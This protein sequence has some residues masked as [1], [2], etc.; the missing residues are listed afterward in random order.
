MPKDCGRSTVRS[1][2]GCFR[3]S[4]SERQAGSDDSFCGVFFSG[5]FRKRC[6]KR[7]HDIFGRADRHIGYHR[8]GHS[9]C[10]CSGRIGHHTY[11]H[12]HHH[13]HLHIRHHKDRRMHRRSPHH[14]DLRMHRRSLPH[15]DHHRTHLQSHLHSMV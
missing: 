8:I 1:G 5:V 6:G 3:L 7:N 2:G 15:N 9:P 12:S 13:S 14:N 4:G 11:H 10:H